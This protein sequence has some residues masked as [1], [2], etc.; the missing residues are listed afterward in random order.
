MA[1]NINEHAQA[2]GRRRWLGVDPEK[3]V[4]ASK[5]ANKA[6]SRRRQRYLELVEEG[7]SKGQSEAYARANAKMRLDNEFS[8]KSGR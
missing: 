8:G 6:K 2:L 1:G 7:L 3:R 4:A 5:S